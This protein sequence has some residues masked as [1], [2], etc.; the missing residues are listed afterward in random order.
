MQQTQ[1][2]FNSRSFNNKFMIKAIRNCKKSAD[3]PALNEIVCDTFCC[4][5]IYSDSCKCPCKS[6]GDLLNLLYDPCC[7]SWYC[8]TR[9]HHP[10][11]SHRTPS[12]SPS[13]R[14]LYGSIVGRCRWLWILD[15]FVYW[16]DET[17]C[18]WGC[19]DGV[20]LDDGGFPD[21][22]DVVV[23]HVFIEDVYT[24]P[25]TTYYRG[26]GEECELGYV[27]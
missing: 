10:Q 16:E 20:D 19:R 27:Q 6:A 18:L 4:K 11:S 24:V 15:G 25:C 26:T 8:H 13:T 9:A 14:H 5:E 2:T 21:A 1:T 17:G 22:G 3:F 23:C 12:T 7:S